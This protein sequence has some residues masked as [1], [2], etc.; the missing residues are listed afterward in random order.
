MVQV[1][2]ELDGREGTERKHVLVVNDSSI[3]LELMGDL[4]E[5][6]YTV[7]TMSVGPHAV[8]QAVTLRPDV[9]LVDLV[10]GERAGWDVLE[11]LHAG[12]TTSD[13][14]IVVLSTDSRLIARARDNAA[15]YGGNAYITKPFDLTA[16]LDVIADQ[17]GHA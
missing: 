9:I 8:D 12:A 4:L 1:R 2:V 16:L 13:I 3:F 7:S 11:A 15:R 17:V 6:H 14:P 5:E 10:V